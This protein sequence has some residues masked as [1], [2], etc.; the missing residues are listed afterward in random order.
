ME[1]W[2]RHVK[3]TI[4]VNWNTTL[5][6]TKRKQQSENYNTRRK[7]CDFFVYVAKEKAGLRLY[8]SHKVFV[9]PPEFWKKR[10]KTRGD[11][12]NIGV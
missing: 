8:S 4:F 5:K 9:K 3:C 10:I 2:K 12:L 1:V 11:L 7:D 6:K